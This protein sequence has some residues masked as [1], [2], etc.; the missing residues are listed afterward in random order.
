MTFMI[1]TIRT[2]WLPLAILLMT[3]VMQSPRVAVLQLTGLVAAHL[4][5]FITRLW[6]TFGGGRNPITTPR[7]VRR[8]FGADVAGRASTTRGYGT[9]FA[10]GP[11]PAAG[12]GTSSGVSSRFGG[13]GSSW[14]GRGTGRR[15]G[16]E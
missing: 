6:P 7:F 12:Q 9:A 2:K 1:V 16:G 4:Y 15:L 10:R 13:F 11:A 3:F 5:D 14:G 8:W